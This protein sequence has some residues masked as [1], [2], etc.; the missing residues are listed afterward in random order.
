MNMYY[1]K[2]LLLIAV[3]LFSSDIICGQVLVKDLNTFNGEKSS[4]TSPVK[5]VKSGSYLYFVADDGSSGSEL[6]RTDGTLGGTIIVRD[7]NPGAVGSVPEYLTDVNG[8]LFFSAY[9]DS[10]GEELWKTDGT[11]AGTVQ[12]KDI[13]ADFFSVSSNVNGLSSHPEFLCNVNGTLFFTAVNLGNVGF[14]GELWKSDGTAAGTVMVKDIHPTTGSSIK[15]LINYNGTLLFTAFEPLSGAELWKSDGTA[16]GTVLVADILPG[17]ASSDPDHLIIESGILYFNANAGS[18]S[19]LWRSDATLAGTFMVADI[20]PTASSAPDDLTPTGAGIFY[21]IA[22]NGSLGRELWKSDG[23]QAG[24][25]LVKDI[26]PGVSASNPQELFYA[27]N[28]LF[29]SATSA[30]EG[31]ELW[32]SD[33]TDAGTVLVKDIYPGTSSSLPRQYGALG[34]EVFFRAFDAG[35]SELWKSDGTLTG[36]VK[37][38]EINSGAASG[39]PAPTPLAV[40]NNLLIFFADNGSTGRELWRSDGSTAGTVL[41]KNIRHDNEGALE[42][43]T[44]LGSCVN[45]N[46]KLFFGTRNNLRISDGTFAGTTTLKGYVSGQSGVTMPEELINVGGIVYCSFFG[47]TNGYELWKSNGTPAGTI[48]VKD[49]FVGS[50][51]GRPTNLTNVNGVLYFS[52]ADG[53]SG[54]ELWKSDGT[55]AGTMLVK[56]IK[57]G[58]ASSNPEAL[59]NLNGILLFVAETSAEGKE[60]WRSDGTAAGTYMVKAILPGTASGLVP[61]PSAKLVKMG[62]SIY[63]GASDNLSNYELWQSD[64]TFAGTGL[65]AN[66]NTTPNSGSN[67]EHL[68][69]VGNKIFLSA[70]VNREPNELDQELFVYYSGNAF[71]TR[72]IFPGIK[73]SAPDNFTEVNGNLYFT[74]FSPAGGLEVWKSDGSL[75]GTVMVQDIVPGPADGTAETPRLPTFDP[76]P[77][78]DKMVNMNGMLYFRGYSPEAGLELWRLN[79]MGPVPQNIAM[80]GDIFPGPQSSAP[81]KLNNIN[82]KLFFGADNGVVGKEL[83]VYDPTVNYILPLGTGSVI[84]TNDIADNN[85]F[86]EPGTDNLI[87][88]VMQSG[89][90][91]L[92]HLVSAKVTIDPSVQQY[93]SAAYVQRHYDIEPEVNAATSTGTVILY[94]TQTDFNNFNAFV[95]GSGDDL[96][97]NASDAAGK[98]NLRVTQYHGIGTAPGNYTG[99]TEVI[100]PAD[101]NIVW[102]GAKSRWEVSFDVTGFSGFYIT[103]ALAVVPV[104]LTRFSARSAECT[105]VLSWETSAELNSKKYVIEYSNDASVFSEAGEI[106]SK[107]NLTGMAYTFRFNPSQ[108]GETFY[109]LK[110]VNLDNTF[111]YSPLIK[112]IISCSKIT[113]WPN[114]VNTELNISG[115]SGSEEILI[116]NLTGQLLLRSNAIAREAR[117]NMNNL[118]AGVY[119]VQV[120]KNGIITGKENIIKK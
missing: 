8:T 47:N 120:R 112:T 79:G 19:E 34:P 29:L 12:V 49:I 96:P 60:L 62:N 111:K 113:F 106:L 44:N 104:T 9:T 4:N 119:S 74:A 42:G 53:T 93:N 32:K 91:P 98:A 97:A 38:K 40:I 27:N 36:T 21:F 68:T 56:D 58:F 61:S 83:F 17:T 20:N 50:S 70:F 37:V 15:N 103:S 52:A 5:A 54:R 59:I 72:D 46:G 85:D 73:G 2:Q 78:P 51:P 1:M 3:L 41:L 13:Y 108:P 30:A 115:L 39:T 89:I 66:I 90:S 63:F 55:D 65:A 110:I 100:D 16:G 45:S 71:L 118:S 94:F 82:G 43:L 67:P 117:I 99:A 95:P 28:S 75:G 18:N 69:V 31:F 88:T 109:R 114:P 76:S 35:G 64:G 101:N 6:W 22:D 25:V 11:A 107:N 102:N 86:V 10:Y 14:G 26:F 23:T 48:M 81:L 105:S 24:T 33:G 80:V 77:R 92:N 84:T 116:Y 87:A 57:T 7:I